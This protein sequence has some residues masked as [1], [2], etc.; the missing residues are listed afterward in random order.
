MYMLYRMAQYLDEPYKSRAG[1]E[2]NKIFTIKELEIPTQP[3]PLNLPPMAHPEFLKEA[4]KF[5]ISFVR[6]NSTRFVPLHWPSSTI[7]EGKHTTIATFLHNW[8]PAFIEWSSC[9][10]TAC[11]CQEILLKFPG[12]RATSWPHWRSTPL[13]TF[14]TTP[15]QSLGHLHWRHLLSVPN[16]FLQKCLIRYH[17][18]GQ[19]KWCSAGLT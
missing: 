15:G 10:P 14:P 17:E 2:L 4:K 19:Q 6:R 7:V 11:H 18:L 1:K 8:K 16:H 12:P 9:P 3:C 13:C 5:I